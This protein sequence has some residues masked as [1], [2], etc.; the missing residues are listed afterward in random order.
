MRRCQHHTSKM[1]LYKIPTVKNILCARIKE[2]QIDKN[3]RGHNE[4]YGNCIVAQ[5]PLKN[6]LDGE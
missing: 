6:Y 3:T 5:I 2:W 4:T 1:I